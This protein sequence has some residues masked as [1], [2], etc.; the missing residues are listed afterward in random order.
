MLSGRNCK[1]HTASW[2]ASQQMARILWNRNIHWRV[3][4]STSLRHI[5]NQMNAFSLWDYFSHILFN[6]ILHYPS[7]E[8][9]FSRSFCVRVFSIS[10][11]HSFLLCPVCVSFDGHLILISSHQPCNIW[12]GIQIMKFLLKIPPRE[13]SDLISLHAV[14]CVQPPVSPSERPVRL[15]L[16]IQNE[17]W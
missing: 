12:L 17:F 4:K 8:P 1:G 14:S 9:M 15:S 6:I 5:L 10:I 16:F 3:L 11:S 13:A 2:E 7:Y